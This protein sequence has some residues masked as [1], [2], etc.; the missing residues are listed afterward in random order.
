MLPLALAN[1]V[2]TAAAL[3][4]TTLFLIVI[5]IM[6]AIGLALLAAY[7]RRLRLRRRRTAMAA[8]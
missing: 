6:A 8:R 1:V 3:I 7:W 5:A 4:D 2:A